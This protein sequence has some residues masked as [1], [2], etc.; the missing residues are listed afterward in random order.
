ML[1]M[2]FRHNLLYFASVIMFIEGLY[3]NNIFR[4]LFLSFYCFFVVAVSGF[5]VSFLLFHFF[6]LYLF[7][8]LVALLGIIF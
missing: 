8:F 1:K 4:T 5:N 2:V 3:L 6:S 7:V